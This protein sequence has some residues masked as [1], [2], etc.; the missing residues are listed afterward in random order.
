YGISTTARGAATSTT[1]ASLNKGLIIDTSKYLNRIIE[2]NSEEKWVRVE[3]GVI[4]DDLNSL[5]SQH[6]FRL[7]PDTSSGSRA[8]I[9]GM[10]ANNSSG[11][12]S[13]K[14]G[15][16]FD[17][18]MELKLL[19]SNGEIIH[20]KELSDEEYNRLK[21]KNTPE[22]SIYNKVNNIIEQHRE[23]IRKKFP[24]LSKQA[25]GY[26][27]DKLLE[28]SNRNLAKLIVGSEG[29]LGFVL[30]AKLKIIEKPKVT[31]LC[32]FQCR[33]LDNAI[34]LLTPLLKSKPLSLE[35][36][37]EHIIAMGKKAPALHGMLDWLTPST[38]ALII[39]EQNAE[40]LADLKKE[41]QTLGLDLSKHFIE[42]SFFY[43][44]QEQN[45]V[46]QLRKN[47]LGL[48]MSKRG[49]QRGYAFIEDLVVP[50]ESLKAFVI[51]LE[52][53]LKAH[54]KQAGIYGH[55]GAGLIHVRPFVNLLDQGDI[56]LIKKIMLDITDM[57][58]KYKGSLTGE[59][60]DG[61]LRSYLNPR[62]FGEEVYQAFCEIK[63][64]FDP[65]NL[66]N[67]GKVVGSHPIDEDL[68]HSPGSKL[69]SWDAFLDF[70]KEK[71][72]ELSVDLC[73]GNALCRKST[74]SMCPSFQATKNEQDSTRARSQLFRSYINGHV[75]I[76]TLL[77][78]EGYKV[79][80]LC[81][82][83]KACKKECPSQV[84]IAKIKPEYLYHYYKI[85]KPS[86]RTKVFAHFDTLTKVAHLTP[87]FSNYMLNTT[88]N[89]K[90]LN[91]LGF[92][93]ELSLPTFSSYTFSSWF[94]A[95]KQKANYNR[96]A[97]LFIDTYTEF[98]RPEVGIDAV[99]VLNALGV[100]I[101]VLPWSCCG[102][103]AFSKGFLDKARKHALDLI[104]RFSPHIEDNVYF[105]GLEPSCT[106][107]IK[108]DL[109]SLV[110]GAKATKLSLHFTSLDSYL[111]ELFEK[112]PEKKQLF[113]FSENQKLSI[114]THC[115]Q[116]SSCEANDAYKLLSSV[117]PSEQLPT[118]CCGMAG[119][120]A[121]EREHYEVS[122][123]VAHQ[124]LRPHLKDLKSESLLVANGFSCQHQM[125]QHFD[126][127]PQHLSQ[128]LLSALKY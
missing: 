9:G 107:T 125:R 86:I 63:A 119:S 112:N 87:R 121:F 118:G 73:N 7:G 28:Q 35:L 2:I 128:V 44:D 50:P 99:K 30:E 59:H 47:G 64:A 55:A 53:Y 108:E 61:L 56:N 78:P 95:Y 124:N 10:I 6:G 4:Q 105:I 31:A 39:F 27:L 15:T 97:Y 74:A 104:D 46:W 22:A 17:A 120:F 100:Y 123:T 103:P 98:Y 127:K 1:G 25:A 94:S 40:C 11:A 49:Y 60:G 110:P 89:R 71:G 109:F 93:K 33:S 114:H 66:M 20:L 62:L 88:L 113:S 102:R 23:A 45:Q 48:L 41:F 96:K 14:F 111:S 79:F 84:D 65:K 38:K 80:D 68:R 76:K 5:L 37:D 43:E 13:L 19:L 92:S 51:E 115:H 8:T 52:N 90:F 12:R 34:S 3:P 75:D 58:V 116:K 117:A 126:L 69:Q 122:K 54:N 42:R 36:I 18:V 29:S 91:Y 67:P 57:V 32:A 24:K 83:C 77:S 72:I 82:E 81:L 101:K 21:S 85:H 26:C 70:S 16:T 106:Y